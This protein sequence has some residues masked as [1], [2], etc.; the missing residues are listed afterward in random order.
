MIFITIAF[1]GLF[2]LTHIFTLI[3]NIWL[4]KILIEIIGLPF[5]IGAAKW[6]KKKEGLDI[7]DYDTN[8][9]PF[10][11]EAE[12][13]IKNNYYHKEKKSE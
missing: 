4:I 7:Y 3:I 2:E 9:I 12:Y 13:G 5:S 1:Y 11:V 8:F 10:S 6:L